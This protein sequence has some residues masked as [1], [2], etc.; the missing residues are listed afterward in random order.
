MPSADNGNS[1][2]R[3]KFIHLGIQ[4][5]TAVG[6]THALGGAMLP[7][8][9]AKGGSRT[10]HGACYHDCPDT[11][12]WTVA[13]ENGKIT[14]FTASKNNPYTAGKLCGKMDS[15]PQDV[16]FHPERILRPLKRKGEK[17]K[18]EFEV[19]SWDQAIHEIT[20]KLSSIRSER[21]GEAILPYN[22]AGTQG[23]IQK[24][25][26]S[27]R[28]FARLG[29]T[30]LERTICGEPA[31]AG[32]LAANGSTTG[33]LPEDIIYSRYIILWGTNTV[34]SNQHLWPLIEQARAKG[35]KLIV[36]DPF[37]SQT[38][39]LADVHIQPMPGTDTVLALGMMHVILAANL[40][41]QEYI[42]LYTTGIKELK[43]HV[44]RYDPDTVA[45]MTG[46]DKTLIINLANEYATASR[47]LIR[48][49]VGLEHHANGANAF[50]TIAMLPALTG[51]WRH[52]GG[53]LMHFTY[54]PFGEALNWER[55]NLASTIENSNVRSVNMIQIGRVLNDSA[56]SPGI[57]ALIVYNSNP[58]VIAPNQNL[59]RKGLERI[60]L[61]TVVLEH[62]ITDTARYADY[63]L[64][65]TTQLEHWDLMTSW[66]QTY[67][68][69]NQPAIS[70]QGESKSNTDIFRLLAKA[71]NF[72][73]DY[74]S[75]A[76]LDI[77]KKTLDS[78][79]PYMK[80]ITFETLKDNGWARLN[81]PDPWIPHVKGN[82]KTTSGKCEF[83]SVS[84]G[85]QNLS[86]L[87]EYKPIE[88]SRDILK[89]YPLHLLTIKS[90]RHFLNSSHANVSH[91]V[92]KEGHPFLDMHQMDAVA[93]N[94]SDGDEVKVFNQHGT[95]IITARIREKKVRQG[96]A[97]MPQGFWP[98]L[99]KGG[100]SANALTNDRLTDMGSGAALQE[101]RV[102]I[103]KV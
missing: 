77:I 17:G 2:S 100:S 26:I 53:G 18:G 85:E 81:L 4:G 95:V 9:C 22:F 47:S 75:E 27:A 70:P 48:V 21:G 88:Y 40:Q 6:L 45:D 91:L 96:V 71:M 43:D 5:S 68:N 32:V 12:S 36:V 7:Y 29:A 39:M 28:F 57:H 52:R 31:I 49:L 83:Y 90:T 50:R 58:A 78:D 42:D 30:K 14:E 72:K 19:I 46:L 35:A 51:A 25:S 86:P 80:G 3:R 23:L 82:F 11:C 41:D 76:D 69:L 20:D 67:L 87:P 73:E 84:P 74:F 44:S 97:S 54:E 38:A 93:R 66:G 79:H 24:D 64:P 37:Q 94:I 98:T 60:D 13:T 10:V 33:V 102:E 15:F 92:G 65:A 63:V 103:E 8:G 55:L 62:F 1:I 59:V 16:T 101:V 61:M 99:M 89:K 56:M 34:N